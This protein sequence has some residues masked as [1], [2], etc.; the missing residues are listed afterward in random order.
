MIFGWVIYGGDCVIDGCLY[1]REVSDYE[2]LYSLDVLGVEDWGESFQLD[3]YIEFNENILRNVDGR[4]EVNV[5]WILGWKLV[6]INEM[7][8]R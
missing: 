1:I 8:S 5:F 7:Q 2:C 6:E 4:Y 3:V